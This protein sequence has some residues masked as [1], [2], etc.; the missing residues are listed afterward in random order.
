VSSLAACSIACL[1]LSTSA[2]PALASPALGALSRTAEVN[3][4]IDPSAATR[5]L[6]ADEGA[7]QEPDAEKP[8][9]MDDQASAAAAKAAGPKKA[10]A[11]EAP[12]DKFAFAKDWPFWVIV[13][14]VVVAGAA[15]FMLVRNANDTPPC[16]A[17]YTAGCFG[18][19]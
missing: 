11:A 13:G 1:A 18:A 15:T 4:R 8:K 14:G 17:R 6:A 19:R 5:V 16:G 3:L 9:A 12:E 7:S 2:N 10:G